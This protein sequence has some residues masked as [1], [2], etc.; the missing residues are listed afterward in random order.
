MGAKATDKEVLIRLWLAAQV[1]PTLHSLSPRR[2]SLAMSTRAHSKKE[3]RKL[4][5]S[6][7]TPAG[8]KAIPPTTSTK[9]Q[10]RACTQATGKFVGLHGPLGCP[11]LKVRILV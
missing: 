5:S 3:Q 8:A 1:S 6:A 7:S 4:R 10:C 2:L 11:R 9:R